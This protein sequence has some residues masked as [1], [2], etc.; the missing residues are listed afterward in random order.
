MTWEKLAENERHLSGKIVR[1]KFTS[2]SKF[3]AKTLDG[4][5]VTFI[6][7]WKSTAD[8]E[9]RRVRVPEEV[10]EWF[11]KQ[12]AEQSR[13]SLFVCARIPASN[14]EPA[15]LLGREVKTDSKG[16]RIVW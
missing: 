10:T 13:A 7:L 3:V 5:S 8:R 6:L 16:T 2:R 12:P 4:S 1:L 9:S 11:L 14:D 15:L